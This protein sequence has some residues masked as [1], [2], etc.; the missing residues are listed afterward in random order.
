[1]DSRIAM[2]GAGNMAQALIGGLVAR[3]HARD[4]LIAADPDEAGRRTVEREFGIAVTADNAEAVAGADIV[5]LAVKP[6]VIDD[7]ARSIAAALS[8]D[9]LVVSVA[10]GVPVQRLGA[11]LGTG[12]AVVRVMPNTPALQ[13]AGATGLF[14]GEHC[15]EAQ[16]ES[17]RELFR[18]VGRVF[19]IDDESLM[20][21]VTAL[22]GSGPA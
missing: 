15:S 8:D 22:S 18:S 16:R 2:I 3:G 20:D 7:A 12:A 6:Q 5:V 14:A 13:S 11:A 4:R 19:E 21:V 17:A 10:A 1:M 9:A